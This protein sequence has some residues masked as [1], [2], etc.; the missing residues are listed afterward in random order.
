MTSTT[1]ITDDITIYA[2]WIGSSPSGSI[3][4][5]SN[6]ADR[7]TVT[8]TLRNAVGYYWGKNSD[9]SKNTYTATTASS[10]TLEINENG[11]YYLAVRGANDEVVPASN[12]SDYSVTFYK[13]TLDAQGGTVS[14]AYII[15]AKNS[16]VA[17]PEA[18]YTG[19]DFFGW[20]SLD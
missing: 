2:H 15:A 20:G 3:G 8:I 14:P 1:T 17:L 12:N 19:Y 5:T 13:I 10:V 9:Y 4:Y 16:T 6:T 7:Q 18:S 11:K